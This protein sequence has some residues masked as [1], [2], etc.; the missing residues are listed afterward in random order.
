MYCLPPQSLLRGNEER[1]R[2]RGLPSAGPL[3]KWPEPLGVRTAKARG[4]ELLGVSCG[5]QARALA[6]TVMF[7]LGILML[8]NW[9]QCKCLPVPCCLLSAT[10]NV[11]R[12][13]A[14]VPLCGEAR[15]EESRL[16]VFCMARC[17]AHGRYL[18]HTEVDRLWENIWKDSK[19]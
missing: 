18:A 19:T 13:V 7:S 5:C 12:A 8:K 14:C 6:C 15:P 3:P 11:T 1:Q 4:Q 10:C 17:L 9:K 2:K 16:R